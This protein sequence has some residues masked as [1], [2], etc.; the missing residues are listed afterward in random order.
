MR[1]I[2]AFL[3]LVM[4]S[5]VMFAQ[6]ISGS[7]EK[8]ARAGEA[9]LVVDYSGA[10]IHGMTEEDFAKYEKH[11]YKDEPVV[12]AMF[13]SS[14][15]DGLDDV[16]VCSS[17][18]DSPFTVVAKI[19]DVNVKGDTR[20]SL[21]VYHDGEEIAV[22]KGIKE[23]GGIFGTKMNL[24]KDGARHSGFKAGKVLKRLIKKALKK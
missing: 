7:L 4:F 24:I 17:A 12:A 2:F 11:W 19:F 23:D 3:L 16:I 21:Y 22:I 10:S 18:V 15:I 6:D 13:H 1:K 9:K 8:L 20:L 14:F 5:T